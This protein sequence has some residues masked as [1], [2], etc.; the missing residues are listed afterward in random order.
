MHLVS[1]FGSLRIENSLIRAGNQPQRNLY[2]HLCTSHQLDIDCTCASEHLPFSTAPSY[3]R[4]PLLCYLFYGSYRYCSH[5][6]LLSPSRLFTDLTQSSIHSCALSWFTC[7]DNPFRFLPAS[8]GYCRPLPFSRPGS[9]I[10]NPIPWLYHSL[11]SDKIDI[12]QVNP[13]LWV[14]VRI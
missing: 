10:R 5:E 12:V 11:K 4:D 6:L 1:T 7:C 13:Y 8:K 3:S 14:C 2:F 9:G